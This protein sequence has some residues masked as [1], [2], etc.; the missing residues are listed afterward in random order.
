M[1]N[2]RSGYGASPSL[3]ELASGVDALYLSGN[4]FL[5]DDRLALLEG[6][7]TEAEAA[8]DAVELHVQGEQ[9]WLQPFGFGKYR[10]R[11][12]HQA[13]LVG[14]TT[15][16]SLPALRVQPRAE[17]L[18][19]VGPAS[20]FAFFGALGEAIAGCPVSW[21]VSRLDLFCD[22]QGWTLDGDS[23]HRFVCRA[24]RRD[25]H[26]EGDAFTGFEFGRR[27]TKTVCARIYDKSHQVNAKGLDWWYDI[28][29]PAYDRSRPVLRIEIELGRQGLTEYGVDTPADAL[30]QAATLWAST[31]SKWLRYCAPTADETPSRWPSA[32]EWEHIQHAKLRG[33]AAGI[34]RIR[35][36]RRKGEIRRLLPALVGYLSR[37]AALSGAEDLPS[38]LGAT[39]YLVAVD[40]RRRGVAFEDRIALHAAEEQRR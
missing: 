8:D 35:A 25:L 38:A 9:L 3:V 2:Q 32:P 30:A 16:K 39:R 27:N 33:D 10:Y 26:E 6:H 18:H 22:V 12:V 37:I 24:K 4:G 21:T 34:D 17:F 14:V 19:A 20:A 7:R 40:E 28:W 29:G 15:S 31:T 23:R 36:N 5:S 13:G 1:T 11:L